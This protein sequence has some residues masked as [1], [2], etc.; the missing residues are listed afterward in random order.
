MV[1]VMMVAVVVC[2]AVL[3]LNAGRLQHAQAVEAFASDLGA[4]LLFSLSMGAYTR[5]RLRHA[6]VPAA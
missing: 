2:V 1:I 6:R 3:F 5:F 4:V